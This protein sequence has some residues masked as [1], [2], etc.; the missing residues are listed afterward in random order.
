MFDHASDT[1]PLE[2]IASAAADARY[3][4][5]FVRR[6]DLRN[7]DGFARTLAILSRPSAADYWYARRYTLRELPLAAVRFALDAERMNEFQQYSPEAGYTST[8]ADGLLA[9]FTRRGRLSSLFAPHTGF[10]DQVPY[11]QTCDGRL[12]GSKPREGGFFGLLTDDGV[13]WLWEPSFDHEMTHRSGTNV[14]QVRYR[15]SSDGTADAGVVVEE[16]AYVLP[17]TETLV[18]DVT[19]V[20]RGERAVRGLVYYMQA[21][22]NDEIQYPIG[23]TSRNRASA[24]AELRWADEESDRCLRVF[25]ARAPVRDAGVA[26][27]PLADALGAGADAATGRYVGGYLRLDVDV[28]PGER[29]S[30]TVYTTCRRDVTAG[31]GPLAWGRSERLSLVR[32]WW[33]DYLA[34]V[35]TSSV[36]ARHAD[37]YR[38]SVVGVAML[39]DPASG[40]ISAAPNSQPAY[41]LS[42]PRD[43]AFAAVALAEAGIAE[44]ATDFLAG[45]C[46]RVQ[47]PDGSFEQCYASTG[48][49]AGVI[50]VENDGPAIYLHAVRRVYESTGDEGFL[51]A[52]WPAVER[53]A[54][55]LA[56]AVV[57]N[58]LL[59]AT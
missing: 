42:W 34:D 30:A 35:D 14:L 25:P 54:A 5:E 16:D 9:G 59:A 28:P 47:E 4:I 18:R 12:G 15:P 6:T 46:P 44:V 24:G 27:V 13:T 29:A 51:R 17:G 7:L 31:S 26:D 32:A 50:P 40:S 11:L 23:A 58:G 45:F 55:Y 56:D 49:S 53:A 3:A 37:Q 20:N 39:A 2:R 43:G 1:A 33:D 52:A 21:N 57:D 8:P 38:R 41:Y 10:T 22:A 36:P 48:E 19:V